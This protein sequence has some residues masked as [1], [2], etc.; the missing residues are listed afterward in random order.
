MSISDPAPKSVEMHATAVAIDGRG[1]L[2]T[3][4]PGSGKSDLALR[5]IDRGAVLIGDDRVRLA[6]EDSCLTV[7]ATG[8]MD[9][10][11]EM[12]GLGIVDLPHIVAAP[13]ALA[14]DLDRTPERLPDRTE[15]REWLTIAV[16]SIRIA[17]FEASAT[18]KIELA[19]DRLARSAMV[20]GPLSKV[21]QPDSR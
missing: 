8:R 14:V 5:L 4:Q 6:T 16:P 12:R 7:H 17:P 13:L 21:K 11:I 15:S 20:D 9:G 3:G 10:K 19:L 1:V 2:L 18:L